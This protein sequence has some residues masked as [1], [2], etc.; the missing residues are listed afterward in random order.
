MNYHKKQIQTI[1]R[2]LIIEHHN[3]IIQFTLANIDLQFLL[4]AEKL[5]NRRTKKEINDAYHTV[6]ASSN[7]SPNT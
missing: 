3:I 2:G 1:D 7:A 4:C 5:L 6:C